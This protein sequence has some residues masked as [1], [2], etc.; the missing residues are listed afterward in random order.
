[1]EVKRCG[2]S[3]ANNDNLYMRYHD[4]EWGVPIHDDNKLFEFLVLEG[5]QA[6]LSWLTVLRK[7]ENYREAFDK[8]VPE[9]VATYD[10]RKISQLLKNP[11]IIRNRLKIVSA[12]RNAD[13]FLKIKDE[14]G[15]FD[16][17]IWSFVPNSLPRKNH[18]RTLSQIPA[19]TTESDHLSLDLK[20]RGF[21]FV[22]S[23]ICYAHMQATGMI[24]DHIVNCFRH[25]QV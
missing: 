9:I 17:Y 2:W 10:N 15:S 24:N 8:F 6:G 7:R 19:S 18:W 1:M 22:G 12:I 20:K 23:T 21:T 14:F 3:T 11:G 16:K 5:A 13:S 4:E 25:D